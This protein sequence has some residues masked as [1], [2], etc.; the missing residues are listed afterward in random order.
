[1]CVS[2]GGGQS[3]NACACAVALY[4]HNTVVVVFCVSGSTPCLFSVVCH[5]DAFRS[6]LKMRRSGRVHRRPTL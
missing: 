5:C 2:E 4:L 1:M 6:H 3:K